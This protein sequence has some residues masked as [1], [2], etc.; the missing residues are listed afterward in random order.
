MDG[1][2][3]FFPAL[4]S[5]L[6]CFFRFSFLGS[7]VA[8]AAFEKGTRGRRDN[9]EIEREIKRAFR[10]VDVTSQRQKKENPKKIIMEKVEGP[11]KTRLRDGAVEEPKALRVGD[12]KRDD[13]DEWSC[14]ETTLLNG[15]EGGRDR[16]RKRAQ[17]GTEK[18]RREGRRGL[19]TQR[20]R[21]RERGGSQ[22]RCESEVLELEARQKQI[23]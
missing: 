20:Q 8:V 10:H 7:W 13:C 9:E 19:G 21:E 2:R 12:R 5:G 22:G 14:C 11:P 4:R 17:R 3:C 1:C 6:R 15:C 18:R 16:A 23:C